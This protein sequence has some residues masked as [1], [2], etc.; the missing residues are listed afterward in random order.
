VVAI[1]ELLKIGMPDL[2][3]ASRYGEFSGGF[4]DFA[5]AALRAGH[6]PLPGQRDEFCAGGAAKAVLER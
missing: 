1:G 2:E 3:C 4:N 5:D 6:A